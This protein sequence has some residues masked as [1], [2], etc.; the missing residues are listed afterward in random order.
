MRMEKEEKCKSH[1]SKEE[2]ANRRHPLNVNPYEAE[3][4]AE[5]GYNGRKTEEGW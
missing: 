5:K 3:G 2:R 4:P 1:L